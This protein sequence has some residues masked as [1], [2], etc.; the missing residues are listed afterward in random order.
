[1][2]GRFVMVWL[3]RLMR[4]TAQAPGV[5]QHRFALIEAYLALDT[6]SS[7]TCQT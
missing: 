2:C 3:L 5:K 4:G 1:M 7:A 6:C